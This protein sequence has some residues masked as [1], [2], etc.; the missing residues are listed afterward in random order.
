MH[1]H[2]R[3]ITSHSLLLKG[4]KGEEYL[5][6]G[7]SRG[8]AKVGQEPISHQK[9]CEWEDGRAASLNYKNRKAISLKF[10]TQLHYLSKMNLK[11]SL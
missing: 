10:Y 9:Q 5:N 4:S 6:R 1:T 8:G 11:Q 2:T 7:I 3:Q